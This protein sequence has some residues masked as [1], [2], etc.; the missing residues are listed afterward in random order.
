[1]QTGVRKESEG[2]L[3]NTKV[4][5]SWKKKT[6]QEEERKDSEEINR[7]KSKSVGEMVSQI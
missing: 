2:W 6:K 3:P 5:S 1:M 7:R 4:V